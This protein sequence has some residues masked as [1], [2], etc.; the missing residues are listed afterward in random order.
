MFLVFLT[1]VTIGTTML[2]KICIHSEYYPVWSPA[3]LAKGQLMTCSA[4][5][6][7]FP[8]AI[9]EKRLGS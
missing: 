4:T 7:T 5:I 1:T 8:V 2:T 6:P 3:T 9:H